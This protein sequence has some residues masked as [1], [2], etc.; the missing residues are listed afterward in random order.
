M[1]LIHTLQ[2]RA[3][4]I[5]S[6]H[7]E[8]I[9]EVDRFY[10]HQRRDRGIFRSFLFFF[11]FLFFFRIWWDFRFYTARLS[12]RDSSLARAFS[13]VQVE[14]SRLRCRASYE[15][16]LNDRAVVSCGI[17]GLLVR[18]LAPLPISR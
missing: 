3:S 6:R 15:I 4:C 1:R 16:R 12:H 11:F 5:G 8:G 18:A 14:E 10:M 9:T 2:A 17:V 13:F 7:R